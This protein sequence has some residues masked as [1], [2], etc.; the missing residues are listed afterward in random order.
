MSECPI[1]EEFNKSAY[2]YASTNAN[3][4][5]YK[6]ANDRAI[7][8]IHTLGILEEYYDHYYILIYSIEYR[9]LYNEVYNMFRNHYKY[10]LIEQY[11]GKKNVCEHHYKEYLLNVVLVSP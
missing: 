3:E 10:T 4:A 8:K 5:I 2:I 11:S 9:Q 7:K 1:C 6:E